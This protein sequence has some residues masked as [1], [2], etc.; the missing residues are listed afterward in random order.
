MVKITK[1]S[2]TDKDSPAKK[3]CQEM[4][5]NEIGA[6]ARATEASLQGVAKLVATSPRFGDNFA[7]VLEDYGR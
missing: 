7:I 4:Y 6:F 5:R 3:K 1:M 2:R